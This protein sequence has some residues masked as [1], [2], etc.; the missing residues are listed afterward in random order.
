MK[1]SPLQWFVMAA[2]FAMF[3]AMIL[4]I[5]R[6]I[7]PPDWVWIVV[8]LVLLVLSWLVLPSMAEIKKANRRRG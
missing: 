7:A 6:V 2:G 8:P 4:D 5:L 1:L 3:M